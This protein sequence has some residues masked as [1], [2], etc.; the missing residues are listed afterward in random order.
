MYGWAGVN[1]PACNLAAGVVL[2]SHHNGNKKG[3]YKYA[4][5]K[6]KVRKSVG[7]LLNGNKD[8]AAEDS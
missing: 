1:F 7:A 4:S 3:F 2:L 6:M 8:L 5:N